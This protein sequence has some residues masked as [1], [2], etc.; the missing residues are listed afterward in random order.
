MEI[1]V[2]KG[3]FAQT[4]ARQQAAIEAMRT[5]HNE[6]QAVFG[7]LSSSWKGAGGD[8]FREC[9]KEITSQTLM[10]IFTISTLNTQAQNAKSYLET[11]D[12]NLA[13]AIT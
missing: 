7:E 3:K 5:C 2:D 9:A 4:Q 6:Q 12:Q 1:K 10:G 13:G 8:A 11:I